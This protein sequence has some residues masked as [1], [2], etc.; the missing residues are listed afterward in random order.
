MV[1]FPL[2]MTDSYFNIQESKMYCF[3]YSTM[4]AAGLILTIAVVGRLRGVPWDKTAE[5]G[6]FRSRFKKS[7][8][9]ADWFAA[10]FLIVVVFST[11]C[12]EWKYEAFW[13]NMGR[14]Q[15]CFLLSWYVVAYVLISRFYQP[16]QWHM[17][18]FIAVGLVVCVWGVLDCFWKSPIG[19]Q[20]ERGAVNEKGSRPGNTR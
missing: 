12:S 1:V 18:L 7:M 4:A 11:A 16:K 15:G 6:S 19:W 14:W 13:G 17:D 5:K 3:L 8:M 20:V 9:P 2:F 10:L